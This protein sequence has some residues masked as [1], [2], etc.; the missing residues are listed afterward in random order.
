MGSRIAVF[1]V[2][3]KLML[4]DG[5]GPAVYD[6]LV[7]GYEFPDNVDVYDLGCLS[8]D[9]LDAVRDYDVIVTVDAL[10]GTNAEPG[11]VFRFEPDAMCH[12][13]AT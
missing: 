2:G 12:S 11:T 1:C 7:A 5:L 8:L 4:D 3:N 9:L 10:D 6:A 13:V